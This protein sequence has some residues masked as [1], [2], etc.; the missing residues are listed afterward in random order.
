MLTKLQFS[1]EMKGYVALG[2]TEFDRG[3]DAGRKTGSHLVVR[4]T[5]RTGWR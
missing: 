3:F 2:E 5:V 1:E 4:L